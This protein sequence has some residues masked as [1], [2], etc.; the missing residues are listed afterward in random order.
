MTTKLFAY[1]SYEDVE[2]AITWLGALGFKT[3]T[4]QRDDDGR[5]IHTELKR[6]EAVLMIAPVDQP[7]GRLEL[8]GRSTG[9]GLYLLVEDVKAAHRAALEAGAR[10]VFEP[11][12]TEWGTER[13]RVLDPGGYEWS[14]G[15]YEPGGSW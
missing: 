5:V 9:H 13:S 10:S 11:E 8:I 12:E 14:F 1:L 7:Y 2:E 6:D 15:T 4:E 3:T